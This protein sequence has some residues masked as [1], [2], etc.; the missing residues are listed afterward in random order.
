MTSNCTFLILNCFIFPVL[1]VQI[2]KTQGEDVGIDIIGGSDTSRSCVYVKNIKRQSAAEKEGR[3]RPGDQLLDINGTCMVGITNK[4]AMDILSNYSTNNNN[5]SL[6][7]ARK[8]ME[9]E[10]PYEEVEYTDSESEDLVE[11]LATEL[12]R[13][14]SADTLD[15]S[16][17]EFGDDFSLRSET[18]SIFDDVDSAY[19]VVSSP[20]DKV[21]GANGL[22]ENNNSNKLTVPSDVVRRTNLNARA[23]RGYRGE[24]WWLSPRGNHSYASRC[25]HH[26]AGSQ[27]SHPK[28]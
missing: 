11:D 7:I 2:E 4:E 22:S 17:S 26:Q 1:C 8:K 20:K 12:A 15:R 5:I 16:L 18:D 13:A 19:P 10:E 3:L 27:I 9:D 25:C 6:V 21:K 24:S 23:R 28:H 14:E